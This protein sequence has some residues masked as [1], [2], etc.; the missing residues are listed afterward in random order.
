MVMW[1]NTL[2]ILPYV[3]SSLCLGISL[4]DQKLSWQA[5]SK[6]VQRQFAYCLAQWAYNLQTTKARHFIK[7]NSYHP[8][9]NCMPNLFSLS[10]T[11]SGYTRWIYSDIFWL[12]FTCHHSTLF[13]LH[14]CSNVVILFVFVCFFN[15]NNLKTFLIGRPELLTSWH[16]IIKRKDFSSLPRLC[17]FSG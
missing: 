16:T 6:L 15:W 17:S 8:Q 10:Y 1:T 11:Y 9:Y 2:F 3:S 12:T 7:A 13:K 5:Q 4:K 14:L